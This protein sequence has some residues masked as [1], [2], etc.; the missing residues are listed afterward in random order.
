MENI[1][2]LCVGKADKIGLYY[3]LQAC[4]KPLVH[5]LI[6]ELQVVFT[7][8]QCPL[9]TVLDKVLFKIHQL[10]FLDKCYLWFDHPKLCQVAW[11]IA[12]LCTEGR[13][14]GIDLTE[15]HSCQLAL[16]LTRHGKTGLLAEEV[17]GVVDL[18]LIVFFE[19]VEVFGCHLEHLSCTFT[20]RSGNDWS[21]E[22]EETVLVEVVMDC[23][24]HIVTNAEYST[25]GVGTRAQVRDCTQV[26]HAESFLLQWILL[27]VGCTINFEFGQLNLNGLTA[28][29]AS[30]EMTSSRD[31]R[32]CCN[33]F[34]ILLWELCQVHYDLDILDC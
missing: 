4:N 3:R 26:L 17:V 22:I 9:H 18:A 12:V 16:Q 6:Q 31:T 27:W 13:T 28:T 20:V 34:E 24:C 21:M 29:L 14:K 33:W 1:N 23:H 19:V 2:T 25:K 5:K 15:C 10:V 11:S 7:V 32:T 8:I 30:N